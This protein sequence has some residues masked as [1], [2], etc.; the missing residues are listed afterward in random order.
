M[1]TKFKGFTVTDFKALKEAFPTV[2]ELREGVQ[3]SAS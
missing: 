1:Q 3:E 2:V